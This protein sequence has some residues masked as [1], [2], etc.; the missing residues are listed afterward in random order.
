MGK[1]G[2]IGSGNVGANTAFFL[3]EKGVADV[4]LHDA[5]EGLSTGKA[6]DMMEAAPI[7]GYQTS[8]SGTDSLEDVFQTD[9]VVIAA[10]AVR[11][12]GMKREDLFA[13]NRTLI[14]ELSQAMLSYGGNVIVVTEPVDLLTTLFARESALPTKR[15]VGLGSFLDSVRLQYL[16]ARELD[17]AMENVSALVIGRHAD[18]MIPLPEYCNVS[19]IPVTTLIGAKRLAEIFDET[20]KAGGL[21]VRMA[22]RANAYYGPSAVAAELAEAMVRDSR[23]IIPVST[24]FT[25]QYGI[26]GVAMGLPA[27]IG[28]SGV[29]R[30]MEPVL[31]EEQRSTLE[32]S[33]KAINSVV[34]RDE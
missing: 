24:V 28:S 18:E 7:R 11:K 17:V 12:P 14:G 31:T 26:S 19:G 32:A 10:G 3:A 6:L 2:I 22:E 8:I 1:I 30:V 33:A 21:I 29:D 15:L 25:G 5:Q 4:L 20:R 27:V 23:R 34:G 16:I 9:I 13:E